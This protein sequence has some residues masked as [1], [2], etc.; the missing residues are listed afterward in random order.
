MKLL[1]V[2]DVELLEAFGERLRVVH[3]ALQFCCAIS[4]ERST[5]KLGLASSSSARNAVRTE[6]SSS[7]DSPANNP[8]GLT[9]GASAKAQSQYGFSHARKRQPNPS[10]VK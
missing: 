9:T 7:A 8:A 1:L 3:D 4:S 5:G 6:T 2:D 10:S